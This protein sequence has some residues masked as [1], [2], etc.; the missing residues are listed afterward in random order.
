MKAYGELKKDLFSF[1]SEKLTKFSIFLIILLDIFLFGLVCNGIDNEQ[2]ANIRTSDVF[3]YKCMRRF[4]SSIEITYSNLNSNSYKHYDSKTGYEDP[5]C[6]KIDE[7]YQALINHP[8]IVKNKA[9]YDQ[10]KK[11][12]YKTKR[13]LKKTQKRYDTELL[14]VIANQ[15]NKPTIVQNNYSALLG[16]ERTLEQRIKRLKKPA[17]YQVY[18]D[19]INYKD[20][21]STA[22][23]ADRASYQ[24][25]Y[26]FKDYLYLLK[27]VLPLLL[28]TLF[29]YFRNKTKQLK[30]KDFNNIVLIISLRR[31]F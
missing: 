11:S 26:K 29:F 4:E 9:R 16:E 1:K 25:W 22:I 31:L 5:R 24:K 13:E 27:F 14:E 2:K 18:K 12:Q 17:Q 8:E 21:H 28:I 10:I 19:Y 23:K 3:T 6:L 7:K 15:K 30:A 20:R